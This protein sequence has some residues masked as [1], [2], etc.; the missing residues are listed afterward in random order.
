MWCEKGFCKDEGLIGVTGERAVDT[1]EGGL[2]GD[3]LVGEA[4]VSVERLRERAED[5]RSRCW[6]GCMAASG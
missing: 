6:W 1:A 3:K 2:M 5:D 4:T